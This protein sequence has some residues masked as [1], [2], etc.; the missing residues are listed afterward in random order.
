MQDSGKLLQEKFALTRELDR[1]RPE[2]EHLQSQL[3]NHQTV[4]AD[5]R[6]LQRQLDSLEVELENEKRS[7]QRVRD[8]DDKAFDDLK[9]R[10][11]EAEKRL[12]TEKREQEKSR[13][14]HEKQ[15]S[16]AKSQ[17]ERLEDRFST[18]KTK[19]QDAQTELKATKAELERYR[20]D[21]ETA[22]ATEA[23]PL[24]KKAVAWKGKISRKRVADES[25]LEDPSL[26]TPGVEPG[27]DKRP[28]KKRGIE[29]AAYGE[30]STFSITPF[31][32]R[33]KN[34][35]DDS[36]DNPSPSLLP[37]RNMDLD[38]DSQ[39]DVVDGEE[40]TSGNIA[41]VQESTAPATETK[42]PKSRKPQTKPKEKASQ[43]S[44]AVIK[45]KTTSRKNAQST[46]ATKALAPESL[47][48]VEDN[49]SVPRPR[50]RPS[51]PEK[52]KTTEDSDAASASVAANTD[53]SIGEVDGKRK[54]RKIL[55]AP[56][57]IFDEEDGEAAPEAPKVLPLQKRKKTALGSLSNAFASTS[58]SPLKRDRRGV[59]A[60][61]LA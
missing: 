59:H 41:D 14:D 34:L 49:L 3:T 9:S 31:L 52:T 38:P 39:G 16:E 1:L 18:M 57:S 36:T 60:S 58:F 47:S 22:S 21:L 27:I 12:A 50:G 8:R 42:A 25:I 46:M 6:N 26:G 35:S 40:P 29:L 30:K 24:K 53:A 20:L 17:V 10:V 55:G 33:S 44:S 4:V 51:K 11:E 48:E 43:D 15:L 5:K 32:H 23:E 19:L 13:K 7:K 54:K 37:A 56:K 45:N 61:F 28:I 2:L